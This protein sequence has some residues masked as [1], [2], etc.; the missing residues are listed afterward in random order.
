MNK[1]FTTLALAALAAV[2]AFAQDAETVQQRIQLWGPYINVPKNV[3]I[4]YDCQPGDLD[5]PG[6]YHLYI[7]ENTLTVENG[8]DATVGEYMNFVL[9]D[10][11][12]AGCGLNVPATKD[13]EGN[14]TGV[15]PVPAKKM[16]KEWRLHF[17]WKTDT[18]MLVYLVTAPNIGNQ[19]AKFSFTSA[20]D[21]KFDGTWNTVDVP[22]TDLLDMYTNTDEET[23]D[24]LFFRNWTDLNVVAMGANDGLVAGGTYAF[25]DVYFYKN[26]VP[27]G[28]NGVATDAEVVAEEYY[29]FDGVKMNAAP[30]NG[31]YLVKKTLSDGTV[32]TVK[33]A[34]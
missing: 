24:M 1:I 17:M 12:W 23:L 7:W 26:G 31:I 21:Y 13:K 19:E 15:V 10:Q 34:K 5:V 29:S 14:P 9:G 25:A 8:M 11:V 27:A 3:E 32:K 28:V 16:D 2:P 6:D 18:D 22:I 30:E 4:V 33:V 20:S